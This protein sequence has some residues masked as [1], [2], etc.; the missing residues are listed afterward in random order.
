M[1]GVLPARDRQLV[2]QSAAEP[3]VRGRQASRFSSRQVPT[4]G[5][6]LA[7]GLVTYNS[8][9]DLERTMRKTASVATSLRAELCVFD[10]GSSDSSVAMASSVPTAKVLASDANRGFAYGVNR[11]FAMTKAKHLLLL[12]PDVE[13]VNQGS[14]CRLLRHFDDPRV[15]I[16]APQLLNPDGSVQESARRFP[17]V[18][19]MARRLTPLHVLPGARAATPANASSASANTPNP[20][21]WAIGAAL[22]IHRA[23]FDA[24]RGWDPGFFLYFEDVDF[25]LRART[26]GWRTIYDPTVALVHTHHRASHGGT[27]LRSKARRDHARSMV[28]FFAKHRSLAPRPP[29]TA[30]R[31]RSVES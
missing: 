28:R 26:A 2:D 31:T 18:L 29:G 22:L 30:L 9:S 14:V 19:G 10:N 12:N 23:A 7:V 16:V 25:C 5:G 17:T 24:T 11:L 8:A 3:N 27:V 15:G 21:D 4:D 13:L 1:A 6:T 20:V